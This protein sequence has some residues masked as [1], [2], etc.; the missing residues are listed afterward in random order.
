MYAERIIVARVPIERIL[1]LRH[2]ILRAGMPR[3]AAQFEGDI[4]PDAIHL[5]AL[6]GWDIVVG[7]CTLIRRPWMN[8]PAIQLRGMAVDDGLQ[9]LGVGRLIMH[10]VHETAI[11]TPE[12]PLWCN[13]RKT[14]VGFYEKFDW[15]VAS[16][17][18]EIPSAGP[19][20]K[21]IRR[22]ESAE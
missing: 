16:A 6:D 15:Q 3:E 2:R 17:E 4:E 19:H 5:A 20:F 12:L 18:F 1:D 21:M 7:C 13:A 10:A 11:D 9:G 22:W 8:N 14:A